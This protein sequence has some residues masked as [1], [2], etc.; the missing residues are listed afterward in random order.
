MTPDEVMR[1][2]PSKKSRRGTSEQITA[3]GH[4]LIFVSGHHPILGTQIL[5]FSD[6]VLSKRAAIPPPTE[7]TTIEEGHVNPQKP[8]TARKHNQQTGSI[9]RACLDDGTC[10]RRCPLRSSRGEGRGANSVDRQS[11]DF[12]NN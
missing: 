12:L 7:F 11:M 6:P 8:R 4:M 10:F 5:Y 1:L 3:P 2:K 9:S